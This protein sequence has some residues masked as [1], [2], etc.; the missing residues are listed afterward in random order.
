MLSE[1]EE[2]I[3]REIYAGRGLTKRLVE[4]GLTPGTKVKVLLHNGPVLVEVRGVK[5]AL[6]WGIA[7][8]IYVSKE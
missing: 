1:D 6:G 8:K 5:L 3:I 2:G 7:T 4:M